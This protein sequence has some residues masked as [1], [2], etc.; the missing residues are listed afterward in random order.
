M[1]KIKVIDLLNKIANGE[2]LPKKIKI[3]SDSEIFEKEYVGYDYIGENGDDLFTECLAN[4]LNIKRFLNDEVEI[5]GED[6]KIE[7]LNGIISD[8]TTI[9]GLRET[10]NTLYDDIS[11][12][13]NEIIEVLNGKI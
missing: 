13:I 5:L 11:N 6:K 2:E 10:M 8:D 4:T 1:E 9:D 3:L 7:K 12:K